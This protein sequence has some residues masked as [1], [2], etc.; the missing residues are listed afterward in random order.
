MTKIPFPFVAMGGV[1]IGGLVIVALA[2]MPAIATPCGL[3]PRYCPSPPP[4]P[5]PPPV[6]SCQPSSS[7]SVLQTGKNVT[8]YVPKGR[9]ENAGSGSTGI[10]VVDI[11]GA[12]ITPKLVLT[13]APVNS[14]ASNSVTGKTVCTSNGTDVYLL[15]GTAIK[16]TLSDG[17][18]GTIVF[19][20]GSCTTC[21]VAMD[22]VHNEAI[23]GVSVASPS[24]S[25][26]GFQVLDLA[27]SKFE[28]P[29]ASP[30]GAISEDPLIDPSRNLLLSASE[31]NNYE[32]VDIK[33]STAPKFF[34]NSIG[35]TAGFAD[36]AGE[37]CATGIALSPAERSAPS[38]VFVADLTQATLTPGLPGTWKR[39]RGY[40]SCP[41]PC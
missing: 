32:L 14:C 36:S 11:E 35:F 10:G 12:S 5:P 19:S 7:L 17:A 16:K 39:R 41:S 2:P 8:A 27:T 26:P 37:D 6:G 40:R 29:V 18:S 4:P 25:A 21:G 34:E 13:P 24:T 33:K 28:P 20:G 22:A 30:S 31:N 1:A 15:D 9:W 23:L 38:Q 3:L